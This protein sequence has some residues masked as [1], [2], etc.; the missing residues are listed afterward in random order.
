MQQKLT[1]DLKSKKAFEQNWIWRTL[2]WIS[3]NGYFSVSNLC[4]SPS[5]LISNISDHSYL[6]FFTMGLGKNTEYQNFH[7][8]EKWISGNLDQLEN[9]DGPFKN[10][11]SLTRSNLCQRRRLVKISNWLQTCVRMSMVII[12][13][14]VVS[15]TVFKFA[16]ISLKKKSSFNLW[17]HFCI[18]F[19]I[20]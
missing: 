20:N 11:I 16:Q 12:V 8:S 7:L 15:C 2:K 5:R 6:C 4:Q 1:T 18:C 19:N 9:M 10:G 17:C 3:F 14:M 13:L